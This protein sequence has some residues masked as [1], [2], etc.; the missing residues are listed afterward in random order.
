M[1]N[2]RIRIFEG[3]T[4]H[5]Q[6][7]ETAGEQRVLPALR[8]AQAGDGPF[9][10]LKT[11]GYF[12]RKKQAIMDDHGGDHAENQEQINLPHPAVDF[13]THPFAAVGGGTVHMDFAERKIF[14]R[15]AMTFA[16][17]VHQMNP[18]DGGIGIGRGQ[19]FVEA[20]AARAVGGHGGTVLRREP[21]VA[22]LS[23]FL[24]FLPFFFP[25][26]PL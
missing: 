7:N 23:F 11:E 13:A 6:Y 25:P 15:A 19:N 5:G 10:G 12:A 3:K 26:F 14:I 4:G 21:V 22:V 1:G 18:V 8:E 16:A 9:A 2:P 20:M 24:L 17:G